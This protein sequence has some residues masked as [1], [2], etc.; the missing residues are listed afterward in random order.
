M[1]VTFEKSITAK[2]LQRIEALEGNVVLRT[3][4]ADLA[5]PRQISRAFNRL[6]AQ[7]RLA[8]LGYGTY[9]K[10]AR[11][12]VAQMT[13]LKNGV[14]PTLREALTRLNVRWEP[15]MAEKDYQEGRSTQ[16]PANPVTQLKDRCRRQ[17]GYQ[18]MELKI[19]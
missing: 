3:D 17:L 6:V 15:S 14:L 10:L 11:S 7:G 4:I 16:I 5:T 8:K 2:V 1:K 18:G 9:A 13:Y 12:E 19:G